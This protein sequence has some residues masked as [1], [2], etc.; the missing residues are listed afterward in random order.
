MEIRAERPSDHDTVRHVN[1][2]AFG[3]IE[4]ADIVDALH[5]AV[6]YRQRAIGRAAVTLSL[7]AVESEEVVG[8]IMFSPVTIETSV[9]PFDAVGLAPM[10][11]LPAHQKKGVG[12]ALVRAGLA[13]LKDGEHR[14]V[15]VLGHPSYYPRFGFVKA[16][17]FKIRWEHEA[18]DEAFMALELMPGALKDGGGVARYRPEF[19]GV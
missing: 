17:A 3:G 8:H 4:E 16:S 13:R 6:R 5:A 15:I 19:N 11:V 10:A 2:M 18:P 1:E 7:V 12:S 14:A 9:G